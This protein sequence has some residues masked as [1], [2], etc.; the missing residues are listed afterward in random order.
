MSHRV[1]VLMMVHSLGHGGTERQVAALARTFHRGEEYEPHVA[2][3]LEG[4]RADELRREGVATVP[5]P[6]RSSRDPGFAA[7]VRYLRDYVRRHGIRLIHSFDAG[8]GPY[9]V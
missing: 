3:V 1:P 4:F 6:I 2:S 9:G 8:L 7:I 5:I